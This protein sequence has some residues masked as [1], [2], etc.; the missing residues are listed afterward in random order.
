MPSD[1]LAV[2][3]SQCTWHSCVG[4]D[5]GVNKLSCLIMTSDLVTGLC[6]Y[7]TFCDYFR[8]NF[9]YLQK[10]QQYAVLLVVTSQILCLPSVFFTFL[11][12]MFNLISFDFVHCVPSSNRLGC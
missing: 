4:D 3:M 12:P 11:S 7:Y 8:V 6:V 10:K 2:I 1:I 5:A 9:F